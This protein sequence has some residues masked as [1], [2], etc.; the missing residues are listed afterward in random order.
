MIRAWV[1]NTNAGLFRPWD[2]VQVKSTPQTSGFGDV[3]IILS[4][5]CS[6]GTAN[7]FDALIDLYSICFSAMSHRGMHIL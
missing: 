3:E 7:H 4:H 2:C 6:D 5:T 1:N